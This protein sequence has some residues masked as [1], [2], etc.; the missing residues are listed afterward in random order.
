DRASP[1][2]NSARDAGT[3][4]AARKVFAFRTEDPRGDPPSDHRS[5]ASDPA[6]KTESGVLKVAGGRPSAAK[7]RARHRRPKAERAAPLEPPLR[8]VRREPSASP[9]G[10]PGIRAASALEDGAYCFDAHYHLLVPVASYEGPG[11]ADVFAH[12][13]NDPT[14]AHILRVSGDPRADISPASEETTRRGG[15]CVAHVLNL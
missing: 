13:G 4:P 1:G 2:A 8:G 7:D 15:D 12:R 3:A 5:P 14:G 6:S 11:L 10:T 9:F